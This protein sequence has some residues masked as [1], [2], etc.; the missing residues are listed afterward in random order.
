MG[1]RGAQ[2]PKIQG[3]MGP[4]PGLRWDMQAHFWMSPKLQLL[5]RALGIQLADQLAQVPC[6]AG[7]AYH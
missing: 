1:N 2:V 6:H 7:L 3:E 5:G 4:T